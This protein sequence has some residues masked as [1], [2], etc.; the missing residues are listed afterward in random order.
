MTQDRQRE[1]W[2]NGSASAILLTASPLLHYALPLSVFSP[3]VCFRRWETW[4]KAFWGLL[5]YFLRAEEESTYTA[6]KSSPGT[7]ER[8]E[9]ESEQSDA[10][11]WFQP[12]MVWNPDIDS[13][14]YPVHMGA[15]KNYMM[16][17]I[18]VHSSTAGAETGGKP[19]SKNYPAFSLL[20]KYPWWDGQNRM[21]FAFDKAVMTNLINKR[22]SIVFISGHL[23]SPTHILTRTFYSDE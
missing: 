7:G 9:G 14:M 6:T 12:P 2:L 20:C 15:G 21:C 5:T 22:C 18:F 23:V 19:Q 3:H 13:C 17:S 16:G 8:S 10:A 11:L 1:H 4:I